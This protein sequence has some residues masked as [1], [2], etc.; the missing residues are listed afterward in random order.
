[1]RTDPYAPC[2]CGS[3]KK[4]KFCCRPSRSPLQEPPPYRSEFNLSPPSRPPVT[5]HRRYGIGDAL[6]VYAQV[7]IDETDGSTEQMR[8]AFDIAMVCWNMALMSESR[9]EECMA[10]FQTHT[11]MSDARFAAFRRVIVDPMIRRH[12]AMFPGLHGA[13]DEI[14]AAI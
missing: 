12:A 6:A 3:G 7:L 10:D 4:Y 1:M 9:R 2:S 14:R 11:D 13:L 8:R 5:P